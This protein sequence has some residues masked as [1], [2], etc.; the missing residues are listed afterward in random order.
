MT[1]EDVHADPDAALATIVERYRAIERICEVVVV[2]GSDY[3]DVAGPT[4]LTFNA[5]VAANLGA[6]V[7][8][9]VSAFERMPDDVAQV[10]E[11]AIAELAQAHAT[12]VGVVANRCDSDEL[13]AV[14]D[15]LSEFGRPTWALPEI[16]LLSA[17]LVADL[18]TALDGEMLF[19]DEAMLHREAE[20]MLVC[21]M[22]VEHVLE[23]LLDGQLC[24]AAGDRPEVLVALAAAHAAEGFPVAGGH[25]VERRLPAE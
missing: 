9:V 2:V 13:V 6:P 24:I 18:M 23:R 12:T 3:T 17:P 1:Y 25:R 11:I 20:H 19:G 21:A 10:V 4:E 14:R 15:R 5:R 16:P 7:L 8:L 22:N